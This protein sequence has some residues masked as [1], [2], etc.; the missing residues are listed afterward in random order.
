[1]KQQSLVSQAFGSAA[2]SYLTSSVHASGNDLQKLAEILREKPAGRVLDLGCGAGHASYA[3][4]PVAQEVVAYDLTAEM[5]ST[6]AETATKRDLQNIRTLQGSAEALPFE[7]GEFDWV[8]SRFSAHHWQGISKALREI[9]RVLKETGRVLFIDVA[10]NENALL[11][12]HLQAIELLR[13]ASHVRNYSGNEWTA[14]FAEAGFDAEVV[15]RWRIPIE[16]SSWVGRIGTPAN[17][18][19]A[20]HT[21]WSG[22]PEEVRTYVA[23]KE[24]HSF[25]LDVLMIRARR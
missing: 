3:A 24:D 2:T 4:S 7:K 8:I 18:V 17:R 10:G 1:M 23:V 20:I 5:L 15:D 19:Q 6:V 9:H 16:F 21:L 25:E 11:D 22:S 14:L 13:D 12:T